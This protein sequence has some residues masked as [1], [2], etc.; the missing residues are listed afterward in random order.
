MSE[1]EGLHEGVF[2][3]LDLLKDKPLIRNLP[4]ENRS[5]GIITSKVVDSEIQAEIN[6]TL[7]TKDA[8]KVHKKREI[9]PPTGSMFTVNIEKTSNSSSSS[10]SSESFLATTALNGHDTGLIVKQ[11]YKYLILIFSPKQII[12]T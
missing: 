12:V 11:C 3:L 6:Y 9:E 2:D 10:S 8:N 1:V 4:S 7:G 5:R